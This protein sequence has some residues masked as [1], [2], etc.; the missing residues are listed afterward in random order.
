MYSRVFRSIILISILANSQTIF[1]QKATASSPTSLN[2]DYS[3][4]DLELTE[5]IQFIK[6]Y[7]SLAESNQTI[8]PRPF[9]EQFILKYFQHL[10]GNKKANKKLRAYKAKSQS[11]QEADTDAQVMARLI[12]YTYKT[13]K[14]FNE[15]GRK[16]RI[17]LEK[18]K[19]NSKI[20]PGEQLK[21][22]ELRRMLSLVHLKKAFEDFESWGLLAAMSKDPRIT[23]LQLKAENAHELHRILLEHASEFHPKEGVFLTAY[24][25]RN[26]FSYRKVGAPYLLSL[27]AL[28]FIMNLR[29]SHFS[30]AFNWNNTKYEGHMWGKPSKY[31]IAPMPLVSYIYNTYRLKTANLIALPK[32]MKGQFKEIYGKKWLTAIE[33]RLEAIM[34]KYFIDDKNENF[35]RLYNPEL[36]RIKSVLALDYSLT[37]TR[38]EDQIYFSHSGKVTC[39]EFVAKALLQCIELLNQKIAMDWQEYNKKGQ[40]ASP[41]LKF[42]IKRARKIKRYSP[43]EYYDHLVEYDL[44]EKLETPPLL[45]KVIKIK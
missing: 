32:T 29:V 12:E 2:Q 14:N 25:F 45:A 8:T 38:L 6:R 42:P 35:S 22:R 18:V 30:I 33:Q 41:Y 37:K 24:D 17:L 23:D 13:Q 36:R 19:A 27:E 1:C 16:L 43:Q 9:E 3:S 11:D 15:V 28:A 34:K 26:D 7:K 4:K 44:I 5:G 39:S 10:W 20:L 21:V 40:R 31:N